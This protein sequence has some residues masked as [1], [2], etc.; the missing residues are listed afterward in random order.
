MSTDNGAT[1]TE[2]GKNITGLPSGALTGDNPYW[3]ARIEAS[4]FDAKT[5][6]VA[7]DGHRSDDLKPYVFITRD[8]GKT[9]QEVTLTQSPNSTFWAF[10]KHASDATVMFAGS[11]YGHLFRSRDGGATWIKEWREFSEI[12]DVAWVPV[13][14]ED[15]PVKH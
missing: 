8:L 5:A 2:V 12:T 4:H 1:F 14:T 3:I 13:R 10:G 11:K 15:N 6:Y 7:I 9:W